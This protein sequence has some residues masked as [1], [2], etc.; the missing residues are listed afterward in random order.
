MRHNM[1]SRKVYDRDGQE[2]DDVIITENH[3]VRLY[4]PMLASEIG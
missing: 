3:A 1:I 4:A 2:L